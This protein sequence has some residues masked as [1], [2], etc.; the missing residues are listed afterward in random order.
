MNKDLSLDS[1]TGK[2][3]DEIL[4]LGISSRSG[5]TE[6]MRGGLI[7]S[8]LSDITEVEVSHL[9]KQINAFL[10]QLDLVLSDT[11]EKVGSFNLTEFEITAGIVVQGKG[12]IGLAI[13]GAVELSGQANAGIKYVFKRS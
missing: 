5:Q 1:N 9:Q 10:K 6:T 11:P 12:Q 8:K 7:A 4:I 13:L 2:V 3:S